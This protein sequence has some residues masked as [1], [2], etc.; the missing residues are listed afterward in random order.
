MMDNELY[1]NECVK[2][3]KEQIDELRSK[4]DAEK[5]FVRGMVGIGLISAG[6]SLFFTGLSIRKSR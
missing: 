2:A 3:N 5:K 6:I 4:F 1:L